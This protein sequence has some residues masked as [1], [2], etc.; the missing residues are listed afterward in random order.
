M[1]PD[2][3]TR[4]RPHRWLRRLLSPLFGVACLLAT[5]TGAA[6]L[7]LL[8]GSI[9]VAAL[10]GPPENPWYALGSNL[11]ELLD[12]DPE[13]G[14]AEPGVISGGCGLPGRDRGQPVAAGLG[15]GRSG[16]R[17]GS[18]PGSTWKNMPARA[19]CGG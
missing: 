18:V 17:S 10:Q 15:G 5:C 8:L 19:D 12:A 1:K 3:S 11:S 6:V 14:D 9:L 7:L 16:S 4:F 2:A 13:A